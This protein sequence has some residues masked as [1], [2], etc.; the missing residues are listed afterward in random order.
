M[1]PETRWR[2][3]PG[4][5]RD[6]LLDAAET[7]LAEREISA[8]AV[9]EITQAAGVSK[10]TFYSYFS[11]KTDLYVA[12]NQRFID[13]LIQAREVR[14]SEVS[15]RPWLEQ[16]DALIE[17]SVKYLYDHEAFMVVWCKESL[18]TDTPDVLTSTIAR[19]VAELE[20]DIVEGIRAGQI[21]CADPAVTARLIV[22]AIDQTVAHDLIYIPALSRLGPLRVIA[23]GQQMVR[24]M[25]SP[26]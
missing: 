18:S 17:V 7:L 22:H 14:L 21:V 3:R 6:E 24:A 19:L 23:A 26:R 10:G 16:A 13:G 25:L 2:R 11:T 12:I 5:R 1:S 9:D 20:S 15:H 8:V 4:L